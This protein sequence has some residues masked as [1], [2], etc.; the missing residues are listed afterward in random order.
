[1]LP[2]SE[3]NLS[4]I[5]SLRKASTR[6]EMCILSNAFAQSRASIDRRPF[7]LACASSMRRLA[8]Y[9]ESSV[10]RPRRKPNWAYN[11]AAQKKHTSETSKEKLARVGSPPSGFALLR[12]CL[13]SV[14]KLQQWPTGKTQNQNQRKVANSAASLNS[15]PTDM[16]QL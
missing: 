13:R 16:Y 5:P 4:G 10:E 9:T 11:W 14:Q 12:L 1:M 2:T 7:R 6:L 3:V 8:I 15:D